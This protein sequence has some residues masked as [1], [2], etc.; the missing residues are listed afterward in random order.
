M[1]PAGEITW[2][3]TLF[4][5]Y[6]FTHPDKLSFGV[7]LLSNVI[8]LTSFLLQIVLNFRRQR[9]G[10]QSLLFFAFLLLGS[11]LSLVGGIVT[12]WLV[13]QLLQATCYAVLGLI[14][15]CQFFVYEFILNTNE[16]LFT[17]S[18]TSE[19]KGVQSK[20]PTAVAVAAMIG[21][22]AATDDHAPYM[23]TQPLGTLFGRA[24]AVISSTD[25]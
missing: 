15:L 16:P 5:D 19:E 22:A 6:I 7:F 25:P 17:D 11:C 21:E 2:V 23:G 10:G 12:K 20:P 13:T 24:G 8:Y 4:G 14:L 18:P 3:E 1:H 9:G